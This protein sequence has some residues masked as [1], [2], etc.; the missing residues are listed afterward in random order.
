MEKGRGDNMRVIQ[1]I[2]VCAFL[3]L[4]ALALRLDLYFLTMA[5]CL[6]GIIQVIFIELKS[7]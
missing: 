6:L 5:F 3:I 2:I 4:S 7:K 1:L